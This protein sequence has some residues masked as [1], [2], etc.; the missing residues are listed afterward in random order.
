MFPSEVF[1]AEGDADEEEGEEVVPVVETPAEETTELESDADFVVVDFGTLTVLLPD[2][3]TTTAVVAVEADVEVEVTVWA[4]V[5]PVIEVTT[6]V[7]VAV[8]DVRGAP[9]GAISI[10]SNVGDETVAG[11]THFPPKSPTRPSAQQK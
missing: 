8:V 9:P 6:A 7:E 5:V 2:P 3:P 4:I 1:V 11:S 10:A